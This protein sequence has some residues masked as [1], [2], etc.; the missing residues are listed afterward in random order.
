MQH[1]TGYAASD[2]FLNELRSIARDSES[3]LI[4]DATEAACGANGKNF[5][6]FNG[7]ADYV[8]FGKRTFVEGFYSRP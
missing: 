6:G 7:Q 1:S 4:V 3:A 8:V 2:S 5:W